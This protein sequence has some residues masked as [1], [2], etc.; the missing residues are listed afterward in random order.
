MLQVHTFAQGLQH[1]LVVMKLQ[2]IVY[3]I[4]GSCF[5]NEFQ[6]IVYHHVGLQS[7]RIL[8]E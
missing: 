7:K 2:V 3:R 8:V 6:L 5:Y 1:F 4:C